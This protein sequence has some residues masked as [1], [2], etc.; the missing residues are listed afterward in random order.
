MSKQKPREFQLYKS[1]TDDQSTWTAVKDSGQFEKCIS[2]VEKSAY[3]AVV[4]DCDRLR[5]A[6]ERIETEDNGWAGFEAAKALAE[7]RK[8]FLEE[9]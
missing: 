1:V 8:G 4:A 6:L 3:D 9:L 7:Y 2:V 5:A